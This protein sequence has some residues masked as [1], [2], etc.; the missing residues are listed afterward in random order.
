MYMYVRMSVCTSFTIIF[1]SNHYSIYIHLIIMKYL[2]VNL[3]Y[4]TLLLYAIQAQIIIM[5][6]TGVKVVQ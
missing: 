4:I 2:V 5:Y 3:L 1:C 6:N